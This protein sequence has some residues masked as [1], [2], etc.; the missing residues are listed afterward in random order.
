MTNGV[1]LYWWRR[2][3][4]EE[5]LT[6]CNIWLL[7]WIRQVPHFILMQRPC[8][9]CTNSGHG[10]RNKWRWSSYWKI[11][12]IYRSLLYC[13]QCSAKTFQSH[14]QF[15]V[16]GMCFTAIGIVPRLHLSL[17]MLSSGLSELASTDDILYVR[18]ALLPGKSDLEATYTFTKW[19]A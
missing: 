15:A 10:L 7:H 17:Q 19:V 11:S 1:M 6:P 8:S 14:Y 9:I 16:F 13:L 4:C 3:A 18:D 12:K 2:K 5:S